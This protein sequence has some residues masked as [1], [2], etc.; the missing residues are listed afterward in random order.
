MPHDGDI[1]RG[2]KRIETRVEHKKRPTFFPACVTVKYMRKEADVLGRTSKNKSHDSS[3]ILASEYNIAEI[4]EI[5]RRKMHVFSEMFR[6]CCDNFLI[7]K[8]SPD[9][10]Y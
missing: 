4:S 2:E 6:I 5:T 1:G 3:L 8:F 9:N 10:F 7:F